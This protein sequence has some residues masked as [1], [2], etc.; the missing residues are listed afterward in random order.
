MALQDDIARLARVPVFAALEPDALRLIAFS[1]ETRILRTGDVLFRRGDTSDGGYVVRTGSIALDIDGEGAA[2]AQI[3]RVDD[4]IGETA[5]ITLVERPVTAIA[6]EPS[7]VLKVSRKLFHR[8]L[9]EFPDSAVR[10]RQVLSERL[11]SFTNELDEVRRRAI[12]E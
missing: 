2:T 10:L 12:D 4:L 1:A 9:Q 6:R 11:V 8:I 3:A 7:T 5:L